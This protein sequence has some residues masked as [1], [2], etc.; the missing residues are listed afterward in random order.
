[1]ALQSTLSSISSSMPLVAGESLAGS[2]NF[3]NSLYVDSPRSVS[4]AALPVINSSPG[5]TPPS[6]PEKVGGLGSPRPVEEFMRTVKSQQNA[7]LPHIT[8]VCQAYLTRKNLK[9]DS[10][11]EA[12]QQREAFEQQQRLQREVFEEQQKLQREQVKQ[13]LTRL[14]E[15]QT[16][17]LERL[18]KKSKIDQLEKHVENRLLASQPFLEMVWTYVDTAFSYYTSSIKPMEERI[19]RLTQTTTSKTSELPEAV[20][21]RASILGR[22]YSLE[23]QVKAYREAKATLIPD[24]THE[25]PPY[26]KACLNKCYLQISS[27]FGQISSDFNQISDNSREGAIVDRLINDT[28]HR[29]AE[30]LQ[31]VQMTKK[32]AFN[33]SPA[34]EKMI[35]AIFTFMDISQ[36]LQASL[37]EFTN[38]FMKD[39][40][41]LQAL[42]DV[43]GAIRSIQS[44]PKELVDNQLRKLNELKDQWPLYE[45]LLKQIYEEKAAKQEAKE[46]IEKSQE[47]LNNRYQE[48]EPIINKMQGVNLE[49]AFSLEAATPPPVEGQSTARRLFGLLG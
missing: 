1:M 48:V 37:K 39:F 5:M 23:Q 13:Q 10:K 41:E 8:A 17:G 11:I 45:N 22:L 38:E 18:Q 33:L 44:L 31:Q 43:E 35:E 49:T 7:I 36:P 21:K 3:G 42:L 14:K 28:K 32:Q 34:E 25:A 24:D 6:S 16:N 15:Q 46:E 30:Q 2:Q 40:G 27:R 29:I 20:T 47:E 12:Q 9:Q 19:G 26:A 4:G